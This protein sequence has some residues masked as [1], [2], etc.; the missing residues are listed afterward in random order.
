MNFLT[1]PASQPAFNSLEV[2]VILVELRTCDHL[3]LW[4][5]RRPT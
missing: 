2:G 4:Y 1:L 5:C 3:H